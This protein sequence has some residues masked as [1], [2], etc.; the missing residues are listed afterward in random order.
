MQP[1]KLDKLSRVTVV[2]AQPVVGLS[3][4]SAI[5]SGLTQ[6]VCVSDVIPQVFEP[7]YNVIT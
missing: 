3:V 4:K 7:V 2:G 5:T 1:G 6:M